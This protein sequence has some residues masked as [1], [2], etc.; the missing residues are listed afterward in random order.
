LRNI[1]F[2]VLDQRKNETVG[3]IRGQVEMLCRD[4]LFPV[5]CG[6]HRNL[7]CHGVNRGVRLLLE[8][9]TFLDDPVTQEMEATSLGENG[10][11]FV[12]G[13]IFEAKCQIARYAS[14]SDYLF[15]VTIGDCAS[16]ESAEHEKTMRYA[17]DVTHRY[18]FSNHRLRMDK[19]TADD[20]GREE[21]GQEESRP[22]PV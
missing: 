7:V 9:W 16:I 22:H 13:T 4:F 19:G 21:V 12:E 14:A 18:L 17:F 8:R 6:P 20:E 11:L 5:L 3:D 1:W 2:N 10:R 15:E